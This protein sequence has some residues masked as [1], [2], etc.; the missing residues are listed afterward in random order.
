LDKPLKSIPQMEEVLWDL[1]EE[2]GGRLRR[3]KFFARCLTV[4]IRY[5]DF[6]TITRSRT[7]SAPTCFDKEIFEVVG[8]LLRQNVAP[9]RAVRLLGVS[10]SALQKTG[11]QEPLFDRDRRR[12]LAKLYKGIDDLRRKYGDDTIGAATP[13]HKTG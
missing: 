6:K 4:K 2:V 8:D 7:L 5:T 9:G 13:R 1:V 11:W 10:A 12:S 3:D